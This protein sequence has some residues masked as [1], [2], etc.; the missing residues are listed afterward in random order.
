MNNFRWFDAYSWSIGCI[1]APRVLGRILKDNVS[2]GLSWVGGWTVAVA[3]KYSRAAVRDLAK[4]LCKMLGLGL[5]AFASNPKAAAI[6]PTAAQPLVKAP[7]LLDFDE[8]VPLPINAPSAPPAQAPPA[9]P[10]EACSSGS[11]F[12]GIP[13]KAVESVPQIPAV[14]NDYDDLLGAEKETQ[15]MTAPSVIETKAVSSDVF[16][17]IAMKSSEKVGKGNVKG[18]LWF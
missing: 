14:V 9:P 11:L 13:V 18:S 5:P 1:V 2:P 6:T 4:R 7:T 12:G 17:S 10:V 3:A 8:P 16:G 15:Q